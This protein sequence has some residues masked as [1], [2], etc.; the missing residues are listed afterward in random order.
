MVAEQRPTF[1]TVSIMPGM[2]LRAPLRTL[3]S[4]GLAG[5]PKTGAHDLGHVR[6][7]VLHF[8]AERVGIGAVVGVVVV[9]TLVVMVKPAG[10]GM[11]DLAHLGQVR[12]L[13]AEQFLHVGPAVGPSRPEHVNGLCHQCLL[14]LR[15]GNARA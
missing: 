3:S 10:T 7:R 8:P 14:P 5:S 2:E 13:A 6:Q 12:A 1:S 15:N 11:P 9:H 4:M